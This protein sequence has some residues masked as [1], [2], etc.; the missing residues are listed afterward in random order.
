[1][2]EMRMR[3]RLEEL[4]AYRSPFS[5]VV[6]F[7]TVSYDPD[8][9]VC[10]ITVEPHL[11][12]RNGVMH[13]GAVMTFADNLCSLATLINT[14]EGIVTVTVESKTNFLR[15]I[16]V[17]QVAR[18][19]AVPL[20]KGRTLMVWQVTIYRADGKPAAVTTQTQMQVEWNGE[21]PEAGAR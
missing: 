11:G 5:E 21:K 9:V 1:M 4:V 15:P 8:E 10:L 7:E 2:D 6:N 20:H 13:G 12:N 19:V 14:P 18:G 16:P 3:E 17:G